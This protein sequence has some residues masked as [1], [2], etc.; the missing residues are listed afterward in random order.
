[1]D[2]PDA[3]AGGEGISRE[4][5]RLQA[6]DG[7]AREVRPTLSRLRHRRSADPIRRQRDELLSALS[8]RR[9]TA[10]GSRILTAAQ[11]G[12]AADDRAARGMTKRIGARAARASPDSPAALL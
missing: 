12:L 6:G 1:M 4:G 8:D 9:Q 2:R 10:R 7:G 5:D 3:R 11:T